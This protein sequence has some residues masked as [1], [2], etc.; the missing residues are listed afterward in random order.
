MRKTFTDGRPTHWQDSTTYGT[1]SCTNAYVVD[2]TYSALSPL[3]GT[4]LSWGDDEPESEA[5]CRQSALRMYAWD[6]TG[7]QP[8]YLGATTS[9]GTWIDNDDQVHNP[10][11]TKVCHVPPLRAEAAF[12]LGNGRK[13]RFALRAERDATNRK[14]VFANAPVPSRKGFNAAGTSDG[15]FLAVPRSTGAPDATGWPASPFAVKLDSPDRRVSRGGDLIL[16]GSSFLE[17]SDPYASA[18]SPNFGFSNAMLLYKGVVGSLAEISCPAYT[19]GPA[20][21]TYSFAIQAEV[22]VACGGDSRLMMGSWRFWKPGGTDGHTV[23]SEFFKRLD[24]DHGCR[25]ERAAAAWRDLVDAH[26]TDAYLTDAEIKKVFEARVGADLS[27]LF[28]TL[29]LDSQRYWYLP[30]SAR[31]AGQG[32]SFYTT[33]LTVA[34][35]STN[36]ATVTLKFLGHD[37]DGRSGEERTASIAAGQAVHFEDVVGGLFGI[38][39]GFGAIRVASTAPLTV[40]GQTST[41]GASGG[42]FGQSVPATSEDDLI[43]RTGPRSIA[44][45]REDAAFRTN[46]ILTNVFPT[47]HVRT[48]SSFSPR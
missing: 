24:V 41:P 42:T 32:G 45:V 18:K 39:S 33:D 35:R 9:Q 4:Y 2:V 19:L 13:Y 10:G 44:G 20:E 40:Q 34:N 23:G 37:A 17:L 5:A 15:L 48:R 21:K 22:H 16:S 7:T 12:T 8:S 1:A 31:A 43:L 25:G 29:G 26:G 36:D 3:P 6:M 28:A 38:S 30:S 47:S 14:L 27:P 11:A 46:L